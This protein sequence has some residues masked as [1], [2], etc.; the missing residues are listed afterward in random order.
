VEA[1]QN[2]GFKVSEVNPCLWTKHSSLGMIMIAIYVDDR[3]TIG[4]KEAIEEVINTLKGHNFN[5]KFE[6]NPNDYLSCKIVQEE[7]EERFG[8]CNQI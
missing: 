6:D 2:C 8:S 4:T 1:L 5:L 7:T 3:L